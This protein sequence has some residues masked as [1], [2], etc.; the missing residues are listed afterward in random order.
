MACIR[1]NVC[2]EDLQ[3]ATK[4]VDTQNGV[5]HYATFTIAP[6]RNLDDHGNTHTAYI[7]T[8][9]DGDLK[10]VGKARAFDD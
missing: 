2:L 4:E 10:Y 9:R 8:K 1:I 7:G 3:A 6:M 5:K